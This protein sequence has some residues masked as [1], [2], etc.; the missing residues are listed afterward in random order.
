MSEYT[1]RGEELL[2][3]QPEPDTICPSCGG[4]PTEQ[5]QA[6]HSLSVL[7]YLHDDVAFECDDCGKQWTHGV[8]I[9]EADD[10]LAGQ[11][12]CDVC[13]SHMRVHRVDLGG[14][15]SGTIE[16]HLKCPDPCFFFTIVERE[17]NYSGRVLVGHDDTTG[18]FD[19]SEEWASRT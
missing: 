16:L 11:L 8:P 1:D 15:E 12:E 18:S 17:V 5:S 6:R 9:G 13:D 4:E 19:Q 7:D 3:E 10:E 2:D 14:I